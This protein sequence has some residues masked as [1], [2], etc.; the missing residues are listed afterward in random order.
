MPSVTLPRTDITAEQTAD[1]LRQQLGSAYKV[2]VADDKKVKVNKGAM[3]SA[4]VNLHPEA[5]GTRFRVNGV[6][7]II[8]LILNELTIARTVAKAIG[9]AP[10][11]KAPAPPASPAPPTV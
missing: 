8:G 4:H 1:A 6:G 9:A 10:S 11:L 2:T 5:N 7:F 3:A